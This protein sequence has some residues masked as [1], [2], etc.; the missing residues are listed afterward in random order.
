MT[1]TARLVLLLFAGILTCGVALAAAAQKSDTPTDV[2]D[3]ILKE[4]ERKWRLVSSWERQAQLALACT[5]A[6]GLLGLIAAALQAP[7]QLASPTLAL[8]ARITAA[9]V[10]LIIGMVTVISNQVFPGDHRAITQAV[11]KGSGLLEVVDRHIAE[12]RDAG[13]DRR[14]KLRSDMH[15]LLDRFN[16]VAWDLAGVRTQPPDE[17]R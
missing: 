12:Y 3:E 7:S 1:W 16:I 4:K 10:G 14:P 13:E 8:A 15:E 5:I 9:S 11:L 17:K 6:I 2:L